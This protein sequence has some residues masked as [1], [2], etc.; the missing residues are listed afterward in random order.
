MVITA[1][2]AASFTHAAR[3]FPSMPIQVMVKVEVINAKMAMP[4]YLNINMMPTAFLS[5]V[6]KVGSAAAAA[7]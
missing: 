6:M 1:R 3:S 7:C 5:L 2:I 4:K